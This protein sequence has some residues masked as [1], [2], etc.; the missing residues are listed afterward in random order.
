MLATS[1]DR[2]SSTRMAMTE[3][4]ASASAR[5]SVLQVFLN[6]WVCVS[7]DTDLAV[8]SNRDAMGVLS[9]VV[10]PASCAMCDQTATADLSGPM[11]IPRRSQHAPLHRSTTLAGNAGIVH[12][13]STGSRARSARRRLVALHSLVP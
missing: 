7:I 11:V 3:C 8:M 13:K 2:S 5:S 12:S 6:A 1:S 10:P 9:G 4:S